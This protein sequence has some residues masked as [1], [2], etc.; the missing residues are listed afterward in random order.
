MNAFKSGMYYDSIDAMSSSY[1]NYNSARMHYEQ[2]TAYAAGPDQQ[3]YADAL[4]SYA[5]SC[6]YAA[7]AYLEAYQAYEEW[8]PFQGR[9]PHGQ[10]CSIREA[11]ERVSR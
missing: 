8:R 3:A 2:M 9:R 10:R 11:G 1:D 5:Q 7:S 4:K 6:M